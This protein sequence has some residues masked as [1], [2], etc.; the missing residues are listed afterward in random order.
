M[1][2]LT[3]EEV[4]TRSSEVSCEKKCSGAAKD[5]ELG[6]DGINFYVVSFSVKRGKGKIQKATVE[7]GIV[8]KMQLCSISLQ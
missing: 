4:D 6:G 1:F 3:G 2:V 8:T 5:V 7:L